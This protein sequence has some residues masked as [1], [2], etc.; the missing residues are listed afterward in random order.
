[1]SQAEP[2]R[3]TSTGLRELLSPSNRPSP[4]MSTGRHPSRAL[5][6]FLR[7]VPAAYGDRKQVGYI[8][9]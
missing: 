4:S 7:A 2:P 6:I 9:E 5:W 1:M 8:G 3:D